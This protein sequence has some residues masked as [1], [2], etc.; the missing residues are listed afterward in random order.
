MKMMN[1]ILADQVGV[2][3]GG[4]REDGP[5]IRQPEMVKELKQE[6]VGEKLK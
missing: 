1:S 4:E 6:R 3:V 5:T 2:G